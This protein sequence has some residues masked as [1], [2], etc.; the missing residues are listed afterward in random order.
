MLHNDAVQHR[1]GEQPLASTPMTSQNPAKAH[2]AAKFKIPTR[3]QAD[4]RQ[5]IGAA[6][7][8]R[9]GD[10]DTLPIC[11]RDKHSPLPTL[12]THGVTTHAQRIG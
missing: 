10:K 8:S 9:A 7:D 5:E 3:R 12:T 4:R 1:A 6:A 2:T 11:I